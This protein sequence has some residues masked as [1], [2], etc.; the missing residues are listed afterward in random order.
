MFIERSPEE[1]YSSVCV[2][3]FPET[4]WRRFRLDIGETEF[5]IVKD[6]T[7]YEFFDLLGALMRPPVSLSPEEPE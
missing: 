6:I 4:E 2:T 1:C 3:H 5:K 7:E